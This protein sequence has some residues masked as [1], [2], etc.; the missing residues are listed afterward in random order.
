MMKKVAVIGH[1]GGGFECLD[2]QTV[3]TKIVTA[4]LCTSLGED[5]VLQ[6][7]THGRIKM[8]LLAPFIAFGALKK[9]KNVVMLPAHNGLRVFAP[10]LALFRP[11]FKG[12][13]LHYAVIGGWLA[14]FVKNKKCLKRA[15]RK[16]DG[17]YVETSTM[18]NALTKQGFSNVSVMPNCKKLTALSK[19]EL[20]YHS[21]EPYKLCTFSRV[22]KGK[23][24]E[25]AVNAV[26]KVNDSFGRVVYTLDIYGQV[27]TLQTE[28]FDRLKSEFP[29]Y[30]SYGGL[31]PFDKSV[32]IIKNYYAL[33]FP[34]H[35]FTEG[36]PGTVIDAYAAGV[37]VIS[38]R[39]E[40]FSDIID[41]G[42]TGIGYELGSPDGLTDRLLRIA[43]NPD[44]LNSMKESCLNYAERFLPETAVKILI[45]EFY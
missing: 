16:F 11:L 23:G 31:V 9:A 15:L 36:I 33:L 14:D 8:L 18:K 5:E 1:L 13:K 7:D 22:S 37:P 21:E 27:D 6:Y 28:W 10:L 42:V 12:R 24:I 32:E 40:S 25:D 43:E 29:P 17:I 44:T 38:A 45:R 35:Y 2:G 20:V 41:E 4:E 26:K 39:W 34:T 19:T 3:K 30:I